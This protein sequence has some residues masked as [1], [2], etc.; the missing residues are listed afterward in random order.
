MS[1]KTDDGQK[2]L[3]ENKDNSWKSLGYYGMFESV[4]QGAVPVSSYYDKTKQEVNLER[5]SE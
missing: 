3:A 1:Q 2:E 5:N 4:R